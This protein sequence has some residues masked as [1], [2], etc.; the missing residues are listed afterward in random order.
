MQRLQSAQD[1]KQIVAK[2]NAPTYAIAPAGFLPELSGVGQ[3]QTLSICTGLRPKE[4]D[5]DRL[6]LLRVIP[7]ESDDSPRPK[8]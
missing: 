1:F 5:S 3:I 8:N 6:E 4:T 2:Q 7:A